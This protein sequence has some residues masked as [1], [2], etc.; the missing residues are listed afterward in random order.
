VN[1]RP[2]RF[3][4]STVKRT[5]D[6]S[7]FGPGINA[8]VFDVVPIAMGNYSPTHDKRRTASW[9]SKLQPEGGFDLRYPWAQ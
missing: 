1:L 6:I 4:V 2:L 8:C 7:D 3:N 5:F 9:V